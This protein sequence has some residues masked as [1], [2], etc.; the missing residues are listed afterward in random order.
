MPLPPLLRLSLHTAAPTAAKTRRQ[1]R[2]EQEDAKKPSPL[3]RELPPDEL[4]VIIETLS[5]RLKPDNWTVEDQDADALCKGVAQACLELAQLRR[6]P[7]ARAGEVDVPDCS[8]PNSPVWVAALVI[9]G[10]DGRQGLPLTYKFVDEDEVVTTQTV[11]HKQN[12]IALC[13][14]FR[15]DFT[16][17]TDDKYDPELR[18]ERL[19]PILWHNRNRYLRMDGE[20]EGHD[21]VNPFGPPD[22]E[23][24]G[25]PSDAQLRQ[26]Q[27]WLRRP[28]SW[29]D[30]WDETTDPYYPQRKMVGERP[31][32][33][34]QAKKRFP[35][36]QIVE[37]VVSDSIDDYLMVASKEA[38]RR[39]QEAGNFWKIDRLNCWEARMLGDPIETYY[40]PD[41]PGHPFARAAERRKA[42]TRNDNYSNW[43][44]SSD[45]DDD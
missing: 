28:A 10:M 18:E 15:L 17:W 35:P 26:F 23:Y 8:D 14:A 16:I 43:F 39:N 33:E 2:Q 7:Q 9:F 36:N 29:Q 20:D 22:D 25:D 21:Y 24:Q 44:D 41:P 13:Q 4:S 31:Y 30:E 42:R 27:W 5:K 38:A 34:A 1:D 11:T 32:T 6:L 12:F 40:E 37:E 3:L 45:D 19:W